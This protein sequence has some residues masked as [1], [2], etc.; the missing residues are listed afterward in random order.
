MQH[1]NSS[2]FKSKAAQLGDDGFHPLVAV[3][4]P[5]GAP[6]IERAALNH[7]LDDV[8][9]VAFVVKLGKVR[10]PKEAGAQGL[11]ESLHDGNADAPGAVPQ[12]RPQ[13][14]GALA[15]GSSCW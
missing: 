15:L 9:G 5:C 8:G 12:G 7:A 6:F 13:P 11:D 10:V 1:R 3:V 4:G 14:T 2:F